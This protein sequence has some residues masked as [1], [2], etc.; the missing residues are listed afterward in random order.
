M[1]NV[2]GEGLEEVMQRGRMGQE[3]NLT[4]TQDAERDA[5]TPKIVFFS[6]YSSSVRMRETKSVFDLV[7]VAGYMRRVV[8]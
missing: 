8:R 5:D 7:F 6:P 3:R 1:S 4:I 2:E